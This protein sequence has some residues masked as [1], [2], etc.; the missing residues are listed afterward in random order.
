MDDYWVVLGELEPVL[1]EDAEV[2]LLKLWRMM[3]FAIASAN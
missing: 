1:D 3:L 2:F